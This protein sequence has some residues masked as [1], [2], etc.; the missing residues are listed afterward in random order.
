MMLNVTDLGLSAS[1][2]LQGSV[3]YIHQ[4]QKFFTDPWG[5]IGH[6]SKV[7]MNVTDQTKEQSWGV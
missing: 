2:L 1:V 6:E 4:N 7:N 5:E 3:R